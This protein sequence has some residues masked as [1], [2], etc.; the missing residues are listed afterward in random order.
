MPKKR[1]KINNKKILSINKITT[2]NLKNLN[3]DFPLGNFICITGVSGSEKSSLII[4]TLFHWNELFSE[5]N[6]PSPYYPGSGIIF[7]MEEIGRTGTDDLPFYAVKLSYNANQELDKPKV[8]IL[9]QCHAEEILGV[10][11]SMEM[12]KRFLYPENHLNDIQTLMGVLY[13]TEIWIVPSH[14]PEGLTVVHGWEEN[15]EWL[16]DVS[17]RKNK[18]DANNNGVFDFDHEGF[19]NDIDD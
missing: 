18:T 11:I 12:I 4:D 19:G 2:N 17:F 3:I 7:Q 15:N 13:Y 1:R 16:Q 5:N 9:G 10:E 8:L 6:S 14:N